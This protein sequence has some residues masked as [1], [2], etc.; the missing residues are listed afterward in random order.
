MRYQS[1]QS[2]TYYAPSFFRL[3]QNEWSNEGWRSPRGRSHSQKA[4][5]YLR[6][7]LDSREIMRYRNNSRCYVCVHPVSAS[8]R[9]PAL[10]AS[11]RLVCPP[12]GASFL[13]LAFFCL[14][15]TGLGMHS[16]ISSL[17]LCRMSAS[18]VNNKRQPEINICQFSSAHGQDHAS[19]ALPFPV[20]SV[21]AWLAR[22]APN[23][24][25]VV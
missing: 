5:E 2:G 15:R 23:P 21:P 16:Q 13:K 8:L 20:F 17:Q 9:S 12:P 3:L 24:G 10:R 18:C 14:S 7:T 11:L 22:F 25:G 1:F 6:I 19:D 4:T